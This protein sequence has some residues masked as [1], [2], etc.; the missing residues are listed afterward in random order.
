MDTDPVQI[1]LNGV[2][3]GRSGSKSTQDSYRKVISEIKSIM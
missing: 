2:K 1:W 3:I